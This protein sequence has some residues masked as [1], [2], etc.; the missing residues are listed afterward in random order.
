MSNARWKNT[1]KASE[2][3]EKNPQWKK[4][5]EQFPEGA[6]LQ[7]APDL[8]SWLKSNYSSTEK[9][10]GCE[11]FG[12]M[13]FH[14]TP[15]CSSLGLGLIWSCQVG[16]WGWGSCRRQRPWKTGTPKQRKRHSYPQLL[17]FVTGL[18]NYQVS[19][20][21]PISVSKMCHLFE[22]DCSFWTKWA[23]KLQRKS[24]PSLIKS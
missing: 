1:S 8:F 19:G 16:C 24:E 15:W 4:H 10:H 14:S 11:Y 17:V 9:Q 22:G 7:T 21:Y 5:A 20:K 12:M 13:M 18:G 6:C 23:T 2:D 3:H